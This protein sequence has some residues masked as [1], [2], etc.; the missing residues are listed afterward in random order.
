MKATKSPLSQ[1]IESL[2]FLC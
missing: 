1:S 2:E